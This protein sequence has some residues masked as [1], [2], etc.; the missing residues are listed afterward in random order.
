MYVR[1]A[2]IGMMAPVYA[3]ISYEFVSIFCFASDGKIYT[4]GIIFLRV[5]NGCRWGGLFSL[6]YKWNRARG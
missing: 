1:H 6:P 2:L 3:F 5:G 4:Y